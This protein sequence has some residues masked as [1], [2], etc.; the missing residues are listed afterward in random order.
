MAFTPL[1]GTNFIPV[2]SNIPCKACSVNDAIFNCSACKNIE[3]CSAKCQKIDWPRHKLECN[4]NTI[5]YTM[6]KDLPDSI[7]TVQ[8]QGLEE[9]GSVE[10]EETDEEKMATFDHMVNQLYI[11]IQPVILCIALS[12][13]WVKL[14]TPAE[15]YFATGIV[16]PRAPSIGT[17]IGSVGGEADNQSLIIAGIIMAQIVVSTVIMAALMYYGKMKIMFGILGLTIVALLGF[18]GYQMISMLLRVFNVTL[19]YITVFF[20]LWNFTIVGI[21]VLFFDGPPRLQKG[22]SIV[23]GSMMAYALSDL[24]ELVTWI[25]L[26]FLAIWDLVAVLCPFGPLRILIE[27]A[28]RQGTEIPNALIYTGS[29]Y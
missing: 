17:A 1:R 13:L 16:V 10:E 7:E 6:N 4:K 8:Q 20:C 25:L 23:I 18:F 9:A 19:D 2:M 15:P 11:I 3:Y 29:L 22:Y 5:A 26:A 27:S 12:L 28:Q 24:P 21:V 14:S